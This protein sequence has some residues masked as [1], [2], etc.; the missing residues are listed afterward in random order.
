M[1][2]PDFY[3]LFPVLEIVGHQRGLDGDDCGEVVAWG[4]EEAVVGEVDDVRGV[5]LDRSSGRVE[6]GRAGWVCG[7]KGW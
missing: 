6:I 7:N 4:V 1:D 2:G 5:D 3:I